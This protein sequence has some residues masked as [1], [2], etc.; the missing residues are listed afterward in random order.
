MLLRACVYMLAGG[1][2]VK[3]E[4]GKE[5]VE[6][7][8]ERGPVVRAPISRARGTLMVRKHKLFTQKALMYISS[9]IGTSGIFLGGIIQLKKSIS[10]NINT[11]L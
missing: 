9:Y 7:P 11:Y 6:V 8:Q 3:G 2:E 10:S 4:E 5:G 1:G